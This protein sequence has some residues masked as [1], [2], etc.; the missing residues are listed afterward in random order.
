MTKSLTI[1]I[2]LVLLVSL[3][4]FSAIQV[5]KL[6]NTKT[7]LSEQLKNINNLEN[8]IESEKEDNILLTQ[9][10]NDLQDENQ[11]LRDSII[12][13]NEIIYGL[14]KKVQRQDDLIAKLQGKVDYLQ[15]YYD[16][17]KKDIA[18]LSRKENI[19]Q[20][21][22][23]TIE[24]EKAKIKE[25]VNNLQSEQNDVIAVKS[26]AESLIQD[27]IESEDRFR[28]IVDVVNNTRINFQ[29]IQIK[30]N[31]TGNPVT[32]LITDGKNWKYTTINFF[33][34]HEDAKVL[35]DEEFL[36]KIIDM[37]Y[38]EEIKLE[39]VNPMLEEEIEEKIGAPFY[40]DGNL[41][42]I[43][44]NNSNLKRGKNFEVQVFYKSDDG[45]EYLL[46][47][48]VKQFIRDGNIVGL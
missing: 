9:L 4:I 19:D 6:N 25:Q 13:L 42:E 5:K 39:E 12:K 11:I 29:E 20:E 46:L 8:T 41:V 3:G 36:V 23:L 1:I 10:N 15:S 16:Q 30:M 22:I 35:L 43:G 18:V 40:F 45:E 21:A 14:R 38:Q 7:H 31:P 44:H 33:M 27:K 26:E 17:M 37:D 47:D 2:S 32:R 28:K 34:N 48:G 24:S